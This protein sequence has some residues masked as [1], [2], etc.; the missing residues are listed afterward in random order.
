M[1]INTKECENRWA[2]ADIAAALDW[3][4]TR[5]VQRIS[6]ALDALG[7]YAQNAS[8]ASESMKSYLQCIEEIS[9][10]KI[11]AAVAV[12]LSALG[13]NL[14]V[15]LAEEN[16]GLILDE[17]VRTGIVVEID[18]EGTP[19]VAATIELAKKAALTHKNLVLALQAYLNRTEIDIVECQKAGLKIRLVK[20]AYR[21]DTEDFKG[22]QNR[23]LK[24]FDLLQKSEQAFDVGTHD[25]VLIE[26]MKKDL[27]PKSKN[28][29][30]FGFLKGLADN[31]KLELVQAG[32][33]VAEYVPFGDNRKAYIL[34]RHAYLKRLGGL[35]LAPLD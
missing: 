12:K 10:R 31:T 35:G 19:T 24:C 1:N 14:S 5:R 3:V 27:L 29:V 11:D 34:R 17:S 28:Q 7:E 13:L 6:V 23:F 2:L 9:A 8:Q 25:P 22:I 20:G 4:E 16:L 33:K 21:G 15:G 18:I 32:F 26:A 30:S